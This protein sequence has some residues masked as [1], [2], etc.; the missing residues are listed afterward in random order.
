MAFGDDA[1]GGMARGVGSRSFRPLDGLSHWVVGFLAARATLELAAVVGWVLG[2]VVDGV[3]LRAVMRFS[4]VTGVVEVAT[5]L[6]FLRWFYL[7]Y[8][9]LDGL[10][11]RRSLPRWWAVG[12]WMIPVIAW[13]FPYRMVLES[14]RLPGA[15]GGSMDGE[16]GPGY[17]RGLAPTPWIFPFWWGTFLAAHLL[18]GTGLG[19]S[20]P[21]VFP[22]PGQAIGSSIVTLLTVVSAGLGIQVVR[23]VTGVQTDRDLAR[24]GAVRLQAF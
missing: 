16:G 10:G 22:T 24:R 1:D 17:P 14:W 18:G 3:G 21:V 8:G 23:A 6:V 5:V 12:A 2:P 19:V 20:N 13:L 11:A 9:N 7:A 15:P 4:A